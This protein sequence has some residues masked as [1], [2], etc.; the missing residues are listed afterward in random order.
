MLVCIA[1]MSAPL[2]LAP[3]MDARPANPGGTDMRMP[4]HAQRLAGYGYASDD[5]GL[6]AAAASARSSIRGLAYNTAIDM[7]SSV[8]VA[9]ALGEF[10]TEDDLAQPPNVEAEHFLRIAVR[11]DAARYLDQQGRGEGIDY[12]RQLASM[13]LEALGHSPAASRVM[14]AVRIL[15]EKGDES[16]APQITACLELGHPAATVSAVQALAAFRSS[17]DPEV[18]R[19]W[20]VAA[21]RLSEYLR[22]EKPLEQSG[23][24][25]Y[26]TWLADSVRKQTVVTQRIKDAFDAITVPPDRDNENGGI[27]RS[28]DNAQTHWA[29]CELVPS[30][31]PSPA[32]QPADPPPSDPPPADPE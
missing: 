26:A 21:E 7:N 18:E 20:L 24:W 12:L 15:A 14:G 10:A 8:L 6:L 9:A 30:E 3:T 27:A 22:S 16:F 1:A 31:E 25:L 5:E 13:P 19:A 28:L 11:F 32:E 17:S 29:T 4:T 2:L 23:A